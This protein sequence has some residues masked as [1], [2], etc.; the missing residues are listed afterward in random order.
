[1]YHKVLVWSLAH[2]VKALLITAGIFFASLALIPLIGFS[3]FP[4]S[5]K[6]MFNVDIHTPPG[7]SLKE[8]NRIARLVEQD[9][10]QNSAIA[11]VST[12]V[13]KGN[14]RVYYNICQKDFTP[15]YAQ[16]FVQTDT[17][18]HMPDLVALTD[19]LRV[20]YEKIPGAKVEVKLFQQGPPV[21]AP[22]EYRIMGDNLD[23]LQHY[24]YQ[25]EEIVKQTEGTIYVNNELRLPKT[26]LNI[27]IDKEKAGVLGIVPAEVAR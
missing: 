24:S 7:T 20:R 13:G 4:Q 3:L 6:T 2:P 18:L 21:P 23:T 10:L 12:N 5:E 25:L 14:P 1:P 9:L 8:T 27:V 17:D 26:D 22:I 16:L 15:H 11:S 19:S